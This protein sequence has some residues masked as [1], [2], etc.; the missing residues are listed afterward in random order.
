[1]EDQRLEHVS[2]RDGTR[3]AYWTSG[4]GSSLVVV[5]GVLADH[6]RWDV[7]RPCLDPRVTLH[8]VD[9]R[10]RGASG[11]APEYDVGREFEDVAAVIDAVAAASGSPV[12][13]YGHSSGACYVMGAA[14]LTSN[15]RRMALYEPPASGAKLFPPGLAERLSALLDAGDREGVVETFCRE[16]LQMSDSDIAAYRSQPSWAGRIDAAHTLPREINAAPEKL[17]DPAWAATIDVPALLFVGEQTTP[18]FKAD[19]EK[20]AGTLPNVRTIVVPRQ[21]HT[22]DAMAP[23]WVVQKMLGFF[24]E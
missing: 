7:M 20:V 3:I 2:S 11:D 16:A 19:A 9:R 14:R 1:M 24:R 10:G 5:H 13:V 12:D 23:S 6:S 22:G 4:Q 8:A 18:G 15:I 21:G 17:F